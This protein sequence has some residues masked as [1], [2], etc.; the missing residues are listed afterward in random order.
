[1][2]PADKEEI[3]V[4]N[5]LLGR[6]GAVIPAAQE[7]LPQREGESGSRDKEQPTQDEISMGRNQEEIDAPK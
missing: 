2:I 4:L 7:L 3:S 1:M 5:K 6:V